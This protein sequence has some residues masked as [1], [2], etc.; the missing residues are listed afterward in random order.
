MAQRISSGS[1]FEEEIGYSRAVVDGGFVFVSGTTGYDY[2]TMTICGDVV[3]QAA[4]CCANIAATLARAGSSMDDVVRVMY[5]FPHTEDFRKCWPTLRRAF[6]TARPA[7]TYVR[8]DLLDPQMLIEIEVT[9]RARSAGAQSDPA[10]MRHIR[11]ADLETT[12]SLYCEA[13]GEPDVERRR[14]CCSD[15]GRTRA[16]T[17]T[18]APAC[19]DATRWWNTSDAFSH[20]AP[21]LVFG[22]RTPPKSITMR[23]ASLGLSSRKMTCRFEAALTSENDLRTD[24]CRASSDSS[25]SVTPDAFSGLRKEQ[26]VECTF[27]LFAS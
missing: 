12:V 25:M 8:A 23:Y 5:V 14:S 21:A 27:A 18:P 20:S 17:S 13:W 9:A 16:S 3:A 11:P 19:A 1:S 7:A 26:A 10:S 15:R 2:D 6:A 4:Q 22:A 24:V